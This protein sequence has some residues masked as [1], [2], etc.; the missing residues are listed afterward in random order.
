MKRERPVNKYDNLSFHQHKKIA[1]YIKDTGRQADFARKNQM[2]AIEARFELEKANIRIKILE[3]DLAEKAAKL[4]SNAEYI[5]LLEEKQ[6]QIAQNSKIQTK[7]VQY[8][9]IKKGKK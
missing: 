5:E 3:D 1:A 8:H 9:N 4:K 2:D 6:T 7:F